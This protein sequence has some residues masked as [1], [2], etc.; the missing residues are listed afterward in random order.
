MS[1]LSA[2]AQKFLSNNPT[3]IGVVAGVRFYEHPFYGDEMTLVMITPRGRKITSTFWELP[4]F[5]EVLE[6]AGAA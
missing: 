6:L 3:L 1:D 2:N 5:D 4:S